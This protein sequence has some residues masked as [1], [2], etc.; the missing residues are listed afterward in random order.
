MVIS[1]NTIHLLGEIT[2]PFAAAGVLP[3]SERQA[4]IQI[5]NRHTQEAESANASTKRGLKIKDVCD[6]VNV[7]RS[8]VQ[9]MIRTGELRGFYLRPGSPKTLRI[10]SASVEAVLSG[11]EVQS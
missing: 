8:T 4:F 7:S 11:G 5:L 9:R 1:K 2:K 10:D 6:L 3:K